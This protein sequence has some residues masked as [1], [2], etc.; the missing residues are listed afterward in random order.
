MAWFGAFRL[1]Y[2]A[3]AVNALFFCILLF[4]KRKKSLADKI[5][6]IWLAVL[7]LQLFIP[8]LYLVDFDLYYR[9]A[10][11][12]LGLYILHPVLLNCYVKATIGKFPGLRW[13]IWHGIVILVYLAYGF[14]FLLYPP[15]V[16]LQFING[17]RYLPLVYIPMVFIMIGYFS[18]NLFESYTTL[19][20]YKDNVLQVYSYREN[21]DLLWL[22]RLIVLFAVITI[23]IIPFG[24][25]SYYQFHS[26]VFAD[27]FFFVSL[28]VFIF[29]LGF[30]G[31][32]QGAVF[33]FNAGLAHNGVT[34]ATDE[35][36]VVIKQYKNEAQRL[37]NEMLKNK[38]Y[39]NATLSIHDLSKHI[40]MPSYMVSKIIN[41]EFHCNFFE[42]V[43][44]YRVEEFKQRIFSPENK[45]LTILG[46]AFDCGFN[47]KSAFNRIF[48]ETTGLTPGEFIRNHKPMQVR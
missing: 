22:R 28:V 19:K 15:E 46:V 41:N 18:Y 12:E 23:L 1:F 39:L 37:K 27:Y 43:N 29:F 24:L 11:Y 17:E 30:W 47:S 32:Q 21:V 38:P 9:F 4:S 34:I 16:R 33:S 5:L 10:G 48:K 14:S 42:F 31:Y 7:F 45:H 13:F 36:E 6:G 25:F 3:G 40:E 35:N 8:F 2:L 44:H 26:F 20:K